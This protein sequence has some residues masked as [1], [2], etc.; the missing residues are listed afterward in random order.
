MS[1]FNRLWVLLVPVVFV[2]AGLGM[3]SPA[4]ADE[5]WNPPAPVPSD[6]CGIKQDRFYVP[7]DGQ[8]DYYYGGQIVGQGTWQSTGGSAAVNVV[9]R[10]WSS[11]DK[12][13]AMAFGTAPDSTCVEAADTVTTTVGACNTSNSGTDVTFVYANTD[14]A[15]NWAHTRPTLKFLL[16]DG[17]QT[18]LVLTEGQVAD[19]G[20]VTLV[21]GDDYDTGLWLPPG[22]YEMYLATNET[23]M[24]KLSNRLFIP[25]CNGY[26]Y[27][28][29]DPMGGP[30][31]TAPTVVNRPTAAI[32]ACN[33]RT[34]RVRVLLDGR[35][36]TRTTKFRLAIDPK[37]GKT[38][39]R[40]YYVAAKQYKSIVLRKQRTGTLIKVSFADKVVK[41]R[42]RC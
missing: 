6:P 16:I 34:N 31:P 30:F 5:V 38:V 28:Q 1:R 27:P 17:R 4:H 40:T 36:A 33:V 26:P 21:G 22:T 32:S 29:N 42:L 37:R 8:T 24:R 35:K 41:R 12:T 13:F 15:T 39:V 19:G 2:L 9:A 3:N 10:T 14:D 18:S 11:P 25:G 23:P 20:Q 7:T